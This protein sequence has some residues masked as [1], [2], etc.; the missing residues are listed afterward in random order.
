VTGLPDVPD[1]I[2]RLLRSVNHEATSPLKYREFER[3]LA[4]LLDI[5]AS[6]IYTTHVAKPGNFD[7]RM[8]QSKRARGAQLRVALVPRERDFRFVIDLAARIAIKEYPGTAALVI[9]DWSGRWTPRWG[10]E[11]QITGEHPSDD[12]FNLSRFRLWFPDYSLH[13]YSYQPPDQSVQTQLD[14]L[15][16]RISEILTQLPS[17]PVGVLRDSLAQTEVP[18]TLYRLDPPLFA[19]FIE[20]DVTADDVVAIEHRRAVV[21][22]FRRLLEDPQFFSAEAE[23]FNG[24]KEAVW[25]DLLEDNPWILG[26]SLAGQVLTS[27]SEDKL[28]Q[29]VAG[30]S[31]GG[32]GKRTDA[33]MHTSGRIRA[34]VFAEIKHHETRL[35]GDEY[36]AGA[37]AP[38][39]DLSGGVAQVQQTVHLASRQ[40]G[41]SLAETDESGAETGE[42]T[43]LVRPRSFLILGNLEQLR[44]PGG[45]HRAK[46]ESFELYRRNLYEPEI[47]TFDELLARAEWHVEALGERS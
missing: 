32:P 19:N 44:G 27:W 14:G 16:A 31:V 9:S 24:R 3:Y 5:P 28:E 43:Y 25:Q 6:A 20:N 12:P 2:E 40:I 30:F 46:Y 13:I 41:D 47:I 23:E 45:V 7:V 4:E 11:P 36:R 17:T 18:Q 37:W 10:I 38:S 34:L 21:E 29:V 1:E 8:T 42:H 26:V 35:L 39:S 15:L 33:L 22:R